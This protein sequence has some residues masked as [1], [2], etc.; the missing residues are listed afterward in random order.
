[1][2]TRP[3]PRVT[4]DGF[5]VPY[6]HAVL[7]RFDIFNNLYRNVLNDEQRAELRKF[8]HDDYENRIVWNVLV[9]NATSTTCI[10]EPTN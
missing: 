1:V 8:V 5:S 4:T 7:I 2:T 10:N 6:Q 9:A 3:I